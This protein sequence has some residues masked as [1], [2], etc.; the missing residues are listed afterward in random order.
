MSDSNQNFNELKR[1][2][3][4]KQHEIPP[5][6]YFGRLSGDVLARIRTGETGAGEDFMD[7]LQANWPF[8]GKAL[9][10]FAARP[11]IIGG[12]A[13]SVC[14]LLLIAVVVADRQDNPSADSL[15]MTSPSASAP[16]AGEPA[17]ASAPLMPA[18]NSG[19]AVSTNPVVSLQPVA[20]LF[21]SQQNPLFQSAAFMP[22]GQ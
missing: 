18:D 22:S 6:G 17:L 9:R 16:S 10:I 14:L 12:L 2:L 21:G 3:K 13:T 11:G 4:L 5:P 15:A 8:L 19:I 20:S 7:R 1:L